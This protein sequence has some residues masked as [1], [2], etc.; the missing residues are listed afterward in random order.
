MAQ[1]QPN[2]PSK[3]RKPRKEIEWVLLRTPT[4]W[5]EQKTLCEWLERK[6]PKLVFWSVPNEGNR[7]DFAKFRMHQTGML[8]GV[9]DL[10]ILTY[11][12]PIF[13]EMKRS[14]KGRLSEKQVM[15]HEWIR[16][17]G[18]EVLVCFGFLD[19]KKQLEGKL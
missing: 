6:Y 12:K 11:P 7:T 10:T 16:K 1:K 4:E 14:V 17:S 13:I 9:P 5:D 19:A 8:S 2:K 18:Y 15:V 3:P